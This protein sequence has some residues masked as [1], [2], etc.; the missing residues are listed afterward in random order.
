MAGVIQ[1]PA[2]VSKW[3]QTRGGAR[4]WITCRR[5]VHPLASSPR[6]M[7]GTSGAPG[8]EPPRDHLMQIVGEE[9]GA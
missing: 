1:A 4:P 5:R 9:R 7:A 3:G 8:A 2:M 6:S